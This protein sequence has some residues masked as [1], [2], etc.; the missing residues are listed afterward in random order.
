M[1]K[2]KSKIDYID[3]KN[4]IEKNKLKEGIS[5]REK[6]EIDTKKL[7]SLKLSKNLKC[8]FIEHNKR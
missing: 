5:P 2:K 1:D 3:Y 4:Q 6:K 7:K 8:N